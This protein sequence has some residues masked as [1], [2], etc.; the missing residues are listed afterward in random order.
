ML[1]RNNGSL[2]REKEKK[3][4]KLEERAIKATE[5]EIYRKRIKESV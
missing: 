5:N 2:D 3:I 4:R 1:D